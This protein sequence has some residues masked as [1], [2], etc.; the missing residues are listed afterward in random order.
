[1]TIYRLINL[2]AFCLCIFSAQTV[3]AQTF[4]DVGTSHFAYE[5][6]EFLKSNNIISGYDDGTFRP[7]K[8]VNRAEA[9]KII[10]TPL[11][12]PEQLEVAKQANTSYDDIAQD[13]WYK[14]YVE[15]ARV[16]GVIDGPPA[17]T[18]FNGTNTVIK[19]EYLKMVQQ[20]YGA[21]AKTAFGEINL[22]LSN[23][24]QNPDEWYYP[25]LRY[26]I[27][28]SMIMASAEDQLQPGKEL[29]RA[30]TALLLYRYLKY[31][32][33]S[34]TQNLLSETENEI[35]IV[36]N[37]LDESTIKKAE[38]AS[39]RALLAARGAHSSMP[40]SPIVQGAVKTAEAFRALVRGY[41]AGMNSNYDE[42]IRLA[43]EAWHLAERAIQLA[44]EL[45]T[46]GSQVQSISK[47]MA[48]S[49]REN[50]GQ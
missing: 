4:S 28:S 42:A 50:M 1:M 21:D 12:T 47:S 25:Y 3:S 29:T 10:T 22:P 13:A 45:S 5:A 19:A 31:T 18:K 27:T 16:A 7:D 23:D 38:F 36:V 8:P 40:D 43:G 39:A 48:D 41:R 20:T 44:P 32:Q 17:K 30:E 26:G 11:L 49:A 15:F 2:A 9:L 46:V 24:V 33:G 6:I 14:P 35:L 37:Y 34:R